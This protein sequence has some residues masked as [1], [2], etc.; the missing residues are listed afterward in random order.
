MKLSKL[1]KPELD[2]YRELANFTDDELAYFNMKAKDY[3]IV[4][5][6]MTMQVSES[7][8]SRLS[9]EV[10]SKIKRLDE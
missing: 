9:R 10:R 1:T 5:I 6:A 7:T 2:R 3:S 4:K 8:I